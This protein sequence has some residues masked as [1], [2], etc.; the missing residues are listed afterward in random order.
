[1]LG[2][3]IAGADNADPKPQAERTAASVCDVECRGNRTVL[4][5][6]RC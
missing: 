2:Y 4:D 5:K 6:C 1:M 3:L